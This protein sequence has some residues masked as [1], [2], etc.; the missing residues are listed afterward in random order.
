[1][2][3][4]ALPPPES[5]DGTLARA[6]T[7]DLTAFAELVGE[8]QAMVFSLAMHFVRDAALAEELAQDVFLN[9]YRNVASLDSAAHL[10]HWLR[11]VTSHR[12]IDWHRQSVRRREVALDDMSEPSVG[13]FARDLLREARVRRLVAEL[14]P[15][16]R[17]VVILRYQEDLEPSA[18]ADVLDMPVNTV[19][20]HLRRSL[21]SLRERIEQ[22]EQL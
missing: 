22:E 1:M 16:A 11:R 21:A 9:L 14:A 13:P 5:A 18:I 19:K 2:L 3:K 6:R 8:Y 12:C 20:S 17:M 10:T 15:A 7:G 4:V